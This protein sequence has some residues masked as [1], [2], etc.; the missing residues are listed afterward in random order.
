M[1]KISPQPGEM[2]PRSPKLG[3]NTRVPK[4]CR[5]SLALPACLRLAGKSHPHRAAFPSSAF[6]G[7]CGEMAFLLFPSKNYGAIWIS[8]SSKAAGLIGSCSLQKEGGGLCPTDTRSFVLPCHPW[9]C[10]RTAS[11][12][13]LGGCLREAGLGRKA[14]VVFGAGWVEGKERRM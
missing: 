13:G 8:K 6:T 14:G 12:L 9:G 2:A 7:G 4:L 11:R 3:C 1:G 10:W 5:L